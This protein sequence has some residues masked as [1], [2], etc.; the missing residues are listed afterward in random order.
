MPILSR[1]VR[2][3]VTFLLATPLCAAELPDPLA[4]A[5]GQVVTSAQAWQQQVRPRTLQLF[6]EQVYGVRPVAKPAV[7]QARVVREDPQALDGTA[8]LKEIEITFAGPNGSVRIHPVLLIP[9]AAK[10]PAPTF[11]LF[12]FTKPDPLAEPNIK[13]A[14]PVRQLLARGFATVAFEV[15]EVDPDRAD[16]F[17][18]GVRAIFGKQPR[19]ADA[20]GALSAWGWAASRIM[21]YLETDHAID[22]TRVAVIGHSRCGKAALWCAAEDQR[23]SYVIS[24]NSGCGG[25]AL[26]RTKKGERIADITSQFPYWFCQNYQ[27]YRNREDDLPV[28]QHQLLGLIA[29]RLLYVASATQDDWADGRSEFESCV[30]ASPVYALFAKTGLPST[31]LP[32]PDQALLDGSI[33]YHMRT[34]PHALTIS[35]WQHFMDFAAKHWKP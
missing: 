2:S 26:A 1:I 14:W 16:G 22:A 34:G 28:D 32:P 9:N 24:N 30:R 15:S 4:T 20:W 11:L 27:K 29:P 17:G 13:G 12:G 18:D 31:T 3:S 7:S 8:T 23:F 10:T 25:A 19:P 21:D 35:D 33:G 6:R 5:T